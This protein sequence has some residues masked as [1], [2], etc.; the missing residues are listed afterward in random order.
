MKPNLRLVWSQPV[1]CI[2]T[3]VEMRQVNLPI[4]LIL[5]GCLAF[6]A[7]AA[8]TIMEVVKCFDT[9]KQS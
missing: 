8:Y 4:V 9:P 1:E 5:I 2:E 3:R 7:C 6:H